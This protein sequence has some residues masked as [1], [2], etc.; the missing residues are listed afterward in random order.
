[1]Q[2]ALA[3]GTAD[4]M[5]V[6]D[7]L[8]EREFQEWA[9]LDEI[10]PI[11]PGRLDMATATFMTA[12]TRYLG[13]LAGDKSEILA[14]LSPEHFLPWLESPTQPLTESDRQQQEEMEM[15]AARVN[16]ESALIAAGQNN[17]Y[18]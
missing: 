5:A 3:V 11:G 15:I 13:G 17:V 10:C 8:T 16:M 4:W 9:A 7:S 2:L 18:W 14:E 1:M 12:V 6:L